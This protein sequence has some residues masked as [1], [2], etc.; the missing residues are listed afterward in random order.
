L[1]VSA[2]TLADLRGPDTVA[3]PAGMGRLGDTLPLWLDDS[4][5]VRP[6]IV[7]VLADQIDLNDTILLPW[8]LR[9][10]HTARPLADTVYLR[11]S[12]QADRAAVARAAEAGGGRLVP[13]SDYLSAADADQSRTNSLA[14]TAVLGLALL[15]TG[16]AVANTLV[17]ATGERGRELA[18]LRLVGAT[19]RQLR[20]MIGLES[21]LVAAIGILLGGVV[22]AITVG[23]MRAGLSGLAPA[24]PVAVP[25]LPIGAITASCLVIAVLASLI[26]AT[27]VL[28]RPSVDAAAVRE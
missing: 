17:M 26:P 1:P 27:V 19:P 22:S 8:Q 12:P 10:A 23:G 28:R 25:W 5:Q 7:A 16:I 6:R 9:A 24:V 18:A 21:V 20:R 11:L 15:Y 14:L 2:G 13:T 4:V 3:V